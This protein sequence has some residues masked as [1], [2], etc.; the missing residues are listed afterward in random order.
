MK[1]KEIAARIDAHLKRFEAD[2]AI[3]KIIVHWEMRLSTYF[4]A[5]CAANGGWIS[6]CY[7]SYQGST[8]IRGKEALAYLA[9]LDAGNIGQH[10]AMRGSK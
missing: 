4:L 10:Y 7:V 6:I 9:W 2:P 5:G 3:N 1:L 8:C